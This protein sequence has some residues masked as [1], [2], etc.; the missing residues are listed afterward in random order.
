MRISSCGNATTRNASWLASAAP[1]PRRWRA[2]RV[3]QRPLDDGRRRCTTRRA[4]S[5]PS[6]TA[7]RAPHRRRTRR[8]ASRRSVRAPR[9]VGAPAAASCS[10]ARNAALARYAHSTGPVCAFSESM[11]RTR[12]FSLS[13]RVSSCLRMRLASY[14]AMEPTQATPVCSR[15][16]GVHAI[17]VVRRSPF[18]HE[19]RL[20]QRREILRAARIDRVGVRRRARGQIDLRSRD[21]QEARRTVMRECTRFVGAHHVVRGRDHVAGA[22]G[23]RP[24]RGKRSNEKRHAGHHELG[25]LDH[26]SVGRASATGAARGAQKGADVRVLKRY[27]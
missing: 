5:A 21:V 6:R 4:H 13:G 8:C 16:V 24:Q 27:R 10:S 18:A 23:A 26:S 9:S 19:H 25:R 1:L 17:D 12:S 22:L 11:L 15:P 20:A 2:P 14:A 3:P 7:R